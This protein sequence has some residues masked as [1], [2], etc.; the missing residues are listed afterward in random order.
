[1]KDNLPK[2]ASLDFPSDRLTLGAL[3]RR[4][5]DLFD[6]PSNDD[7][8]SECPFLTD[9]RGRGFGMR[10]RLYAL[11]DT[12]RQ[13][14]L[15]ALVAAQGKTRDDWFQS[16]QEEWRTLAEL[17]HEYGIAQG[18]EHAGQLIRD[19]EQAAASLAERGS[20]R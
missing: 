9:D 2:L 14:A 15:N 17:Y 8:L 13:V 7:S 1:M 10:D 12:E 3:R 6:Q 20:R 5:P 19:L 4:F 11:L 16:P 18:P